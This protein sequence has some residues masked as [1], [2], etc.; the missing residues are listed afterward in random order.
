M[1]GKVSRPRTGSPATGKLVSPEAVR[2]QVAL[3]LA[4][5][6][7]DEPSSVAAYRAD[8][9]K[10]PAADLMGIYARFQTGPPPYELAAATTTWPKARRPDVPDS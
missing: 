10:P 6:V 2:T 3:F 9:P 5:E 8:G 4:F 1:R 7:A